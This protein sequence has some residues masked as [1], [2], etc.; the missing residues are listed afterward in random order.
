MNEK[1]TSQLAI[2]WTGDLNDDCTAEW[3]GLILR[4]ES[5]ERSNWWWAVADAATGVEIDSSNYSPYIAV[6]FKSGSAARRAA[7]AAARNYVNQRQS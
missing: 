4:A 2:R 7:E 3:A 5:M 1:P 6:D